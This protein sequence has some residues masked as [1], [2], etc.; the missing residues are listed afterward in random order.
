MDSKGSRKK[1]VAQAAAAA[2]QVAPPPLP[3]DPV[4]E[5]APS[6]ASPAARRPGLAPR[7]PGSVVVPRSD[8]A[9][10][11]ESGPSEAVEHRHF[12]R[13]RLATRFALWIDDQR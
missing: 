3:V 8:V 7:F 1:V 11:I 13:A 2:P 5:V 4:E 12:P 10:I 6:V 9:P